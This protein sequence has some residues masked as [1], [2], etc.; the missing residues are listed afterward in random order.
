MPSKK[1]KKTAMK[2][3]IREV[4]LSKVKPFEGNPRT[5]SED[6][7]KGLSN[8]L[9]RFGYVDLIV[10]N[11]RTGNIVGGH[12]RYSILMSKG[13]K[14]AKMIVVD[15]SSEDEVAANLT[16]NNPEIEGEWDDPITE[17][18]DRIEEV[19]PDLFSDANFDDLLAGVEAMVPRRGE[20]S[21][22]GKNQEIDIDELLAD[23]NG[24]CPCCD[25]DWEM[26]DKDVSSMSEKERK[27][28]A[29]G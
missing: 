22:E 21:Y 25:F 2:W 29:N 1:Q 7:R 27:E 13:V 3:E 18:L 4:D 26:D 16:L 28:I 6:S 10:W 11:E 23:C 12:Q 20:D 8:V 14:K 9:E 19:S 15:F 17:L 24:H 5:I